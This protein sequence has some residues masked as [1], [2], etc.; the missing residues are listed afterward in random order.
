MAMTKKHF[1]QLAAIL[2]F[3]GRQADTDGEKEI[4]QETVRHIA[5]LCAEDNAN[6]NRVSFYLAC[7]PAIRLTR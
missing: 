5:N 3:V 4:V 1:I 7:N 2:Q 6:F